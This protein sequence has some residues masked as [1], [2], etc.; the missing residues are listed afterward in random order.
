MGGD[1]D[2]AIC[3]RSAQ[4]QA[5]ASGICGGQSSIAKGFSPSTSVSSYQYRSANS[6]CPFIHLSHTIYDL[7]N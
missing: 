2:H 3:R 5:I 6:P 1:T 7:R 4:F